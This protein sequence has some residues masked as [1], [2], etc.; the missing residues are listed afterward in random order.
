[1]RYPG[2]HDEPTDGAGGDRGPLGDDDVGVRGRARRLGTG[3]SADRGRHGGHRQPPPGHRLDEA[4]R[5]RPG[6]A[7]RRAHRLRPLVLAG[8]LA[9]RHGPRGRRGGARRRRRALRAPP[10][11]SQR[12]ARSGDPR[13]GRRLRGRPLRVQGARRVRRPA[14][15]R[16]HVH[17]AVFLRQPVPLPPPPLRRRHLRAVGEERPRR[18]DHRPP[19]DHRATPLVHRGLGDRRLRALRSV[20]RRARGSTSASSR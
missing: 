13:R 7:R 20:G 6:S 14:R 4:R 17:L 10:R 18:A 2:A 5:R 1:M 19:S 8:R 9:R 16:K 11:G 12:L 15:Q 3:G